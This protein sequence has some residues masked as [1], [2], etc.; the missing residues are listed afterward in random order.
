LIYTLSVLSYLKLFWK[1]DF[2]SKCIGLGALSFCLFILATAGIWPVGLALLMA[3]T[4]L[5]FFFL[6]KRNATIA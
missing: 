2:Q 1:K 3:F 5:P 4:G 6:K